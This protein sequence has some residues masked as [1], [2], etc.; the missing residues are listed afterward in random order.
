MPSNAILRS[1]HPRAPGR[2]VLQE[3]KGVIDGIQQLDGKIERMVHD[4]YTAQPLAGMSRTSK[5]ETT[6]TDQ[7]QKRLE[8]ITCTQCCTTGQTMSARRS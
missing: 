3:T 1:K 7:L 6:V 4:F 8:L 5:L 2:L